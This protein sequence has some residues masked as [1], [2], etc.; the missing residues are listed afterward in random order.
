MVS[1]S[2]VEVRL[3]VKDE[4]SPVIRRLTWRLWIFQHRDV[5]V[6]AV[7][8]LVVFVLGLVGGRIL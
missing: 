4:V 6:A 1:L 2:D 5:M 3:R 7:W 8:T